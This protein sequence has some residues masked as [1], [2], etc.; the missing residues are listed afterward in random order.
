MEK[1]RIKPNLLDI[2]AAGGGTGFLPIAPGTWGAAAAAIIYYYFLYYLP[3]WAITA[4]IAATYALGTIAADSFDLRR[5]TKDNG[6]IVIDEFVGQWITLLA[7]PHTLICTA[8]GFFIF[9][10]FDI[11]KPPPIRLIEKRIRGGHGV[12]AD[13]AVAGIYS[14]LTLQALIL[15]FPNILL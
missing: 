2:V 13:D 8:A 11:L 7:A 9:R 6:S 10:I 12:M 4:T 14:W 5:G 3:L 15:L 1:Q